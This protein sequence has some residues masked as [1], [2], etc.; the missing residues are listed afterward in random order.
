MRIAFFLACILAVWVGA[1]APA[2]GDKPGGG[3]I[4]LEIS[5]DKAEYPFRSAIAL[6][7]TYTN[8]SKETVALMANGATPGEGFAGEAFE[9]SSGAG[10]TTYTIVGVDPMVETIT[11]EPGKSWSRTIK[12]LAPAL[13]NT[14][15]KAD[16]RAAVE[17]DR[18]P[19]PF[20]RA[21]E[22]TVRL[23]FRSAVRAQPK[24]AFNGKVESN[25]V[26]FKVV[27]R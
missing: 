7:I 8:T 20:G 13:S 4:R 6:T 27:M 24:P 25:A 10:R 11:I 22:Y 16:G 17:G 19:D 26:K 21:D 18:Q 14:G 9:V 12:D 23:S 2:G 1:D 5:A 3:P 15:V